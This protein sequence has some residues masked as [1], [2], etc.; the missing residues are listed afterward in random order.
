MATL[1]IS[2]YAGV[3]HNC[4]QDPM[5]TQALTTSGTSAQSTAN[6]NG[7]S[8]AMLFSDVAHYVT[9]GSDPT[10][11][12]ANSVLVPGGVPIWLRLTMG[13]KLAALTV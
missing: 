9:E 5:G 3:S 10:A 1:Y 2:R 6:T 7:A 12:T 11:T 13:H 4:G 8:V